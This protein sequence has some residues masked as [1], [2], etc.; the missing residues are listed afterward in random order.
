MSKLLLMTQFSIFLF[1]A[2][3][4]QITFILNNKFI[5]PIPRIPP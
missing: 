2:E 4:E 3:P 1:K 5:F